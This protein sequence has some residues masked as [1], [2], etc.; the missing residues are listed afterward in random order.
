MKSLACFSWHC[1]HVFVTSG[2]LVKGPLTRSAWFPANARPANMTAMQI[3]IILLA[4]FFIY[5]F[6]LRCFKKTDSIEAHSLF[7]QG[8]H[9]KKALHSREGNASLKTSVLK[10]CRVITGSLR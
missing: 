10:C 6:L 8:H 7:V 1:R 4:S 9:S 3:T 5:F 2:P